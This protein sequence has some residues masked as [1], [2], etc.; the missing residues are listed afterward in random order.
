MTD[1][2]LDSPIRDL[3]LLRL[4]RDAD[5][6]P[7]AAPTLPGDRAMVGRVTSTSGIAVGK[8]LTV[9]PVRLL[10]TE[11]EGGTGSLT[12]QTSA[13]IPV[14]LVGPGVPTTGK[15]LICRRL[16]HRWAAD[17]DTISAGGG[18]IPIAG[19]QCATQT[20]ASIIWTSTDPYLPSCTITYQPTPFPPG[21]F[22]DASGNMYCGPIMFDV[23][24]SGNVF[25]Y[26]IFLY[27]NGQYRIGRLTY[28]DPSIG[29]VGGY[30]F[31][32]RFFTIANPINK[33]SPWKFTVSSSQINVGLTD[34]SMAPGP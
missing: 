11:A 23:D 14:Y 4:M 16:G 9:N 20:P 22:E 12:V 5:R 27:C 15:D 28:S 1:D 32:A 7:L 6:L 25:R 18:T 10:G 26:R 17:Y 30:Q 24:G 31:D 33:C 19:C 34:I 8:Y 29:Y 2:D 13:T 21:G 3:E